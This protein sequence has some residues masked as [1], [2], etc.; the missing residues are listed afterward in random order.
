M[1]IKQDNLYLCPDC[2]V[3]IDGWFRKWYIRR[4]CKCNDLA[5]KTKYAVT[6]IL[7]TTIIL[8]KPTPVSTLE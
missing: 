7:G 1:M 6:D 2:F 4:N 8:Q 5:V 3:R